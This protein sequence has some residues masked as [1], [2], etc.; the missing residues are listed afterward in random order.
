[1]G[2][3]RGYEGY[4]VLNKWLPSRFI[5]RTRAEAA[6]ILLRFFVEDAIPNV[7]INIV[8]IKKVDEEILYS[9]FQYSSQMW[10]KLERKVALQAIIKGKF[11]FSADRIFHIWVDQ[12]YADYA[13]RPTLAGAKHTTSSSVGGDHESST[14][15]ISSLKLLSSFMKKGYQRVRQSS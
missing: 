11:E 1:M 2:A 12:D 6:E 3:P 14:G 7:L 4:V 13:I 8:P 15:K 10:Q 5:G 9:F